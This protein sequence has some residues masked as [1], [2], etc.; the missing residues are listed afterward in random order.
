MI[1]LRYFVLHSCRCA[2]LVAITAKGTV[3]DGIGT[4]G[5]VGYADYGTNFAPA[6]YQS[7]QVNLD[8]YINGQPVFGVY[9]GYNGVWHMM[10]SVPLEA[11]PHSSFAGIESS[12][13]GCLTGYV[14]FQKNQYQPSQGGTFTAYCYNTVIHNYDLPNS[15]CFN[16]KGEQ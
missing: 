9:I 11:S 14:S 8:T 3:G 15:G 2:F 13:A 16:G 10:T 7:Y 5:Y 1:V 4:T 6:S 12:T